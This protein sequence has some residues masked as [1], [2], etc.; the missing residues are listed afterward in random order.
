MTQNHEKVLVDLLIKP[1]PIKGITILLI[2]TLLFV[3]GIS[4]LLQSFDYH[5]LYGKYNPILDTITIY[6][7][8]ENVEQTINT[9]WHEVGHYY[10]YQFLNNNKD[11]S[12]EEFA[13]HFKEYYKNAVIE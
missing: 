7:H 9:C 13:E 12:N 2:I 10:C 5:E 8:G 6:P 3:I 4:F 1:I 11:C